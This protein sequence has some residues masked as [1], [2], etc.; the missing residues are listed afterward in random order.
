MTKFQSVLEVLKNRRV[1]VAIVGAIAFGM[2]A[3]NIQANINIDTYADLITKFIT[4]SCDLLAAG[5]ALHS[6]LFPKN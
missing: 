4:A 3:F 1:W 5:L 2:T 6:Y